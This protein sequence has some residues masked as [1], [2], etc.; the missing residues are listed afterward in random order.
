ML[1][2]FICPLTLPGQKMPRTL[3]S[4]QRGE[5]KTTNA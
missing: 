5:E 3:P 1:L 4:P 2:P